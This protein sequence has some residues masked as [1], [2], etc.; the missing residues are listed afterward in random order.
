M[1]LAT[2]VENVC[3]GLYRKRVTVLYCSTVLLVYS[4]YCCWY[5]VHISV[6]LLVPGAI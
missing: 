5:A 2:T 1:P 6:L 3:G 4:R